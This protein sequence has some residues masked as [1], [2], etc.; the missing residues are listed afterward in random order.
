MQDRPI[1]LNCTRMNIIIPMAGRGTRLRPHT[2]ATP[3]PLLKIGG[4]TIVQR[5]CEEIRG[6]YNSPIDTI[7]F[8]IGDFGAAVEQELLA[9][10]ES[11]G[12]KGKIC[13]QNEPLGTA[14]AIWQAEECL[15]GETIIAFADTLFK[16][17]F[18]LDNTADGVIWVKTVDNPKAFGVV[19]LDA[20]GVINGMVEKPQEFVSDLA[21]IGIYYVKQ[22]ETLHAEIKYLLDNDIREKGEYQLTNALENMRLKGAQFVPGK[23]DSWMDCGNKEA[24]LDTMKHTLAF[25]HSAGKITPPADLKST[26]SVIIPPCYL[27]KGVVLENAVIGPFVSLG[28]NTI[29]KNSVLSMTMAQDHCTIENHVMT[30]S[31]LGGHVRV[32]KPAGILDIG[33]YSKL[34]G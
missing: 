15:K 31:M 23:V 2:I 19:T 25:D 29:V 24:V 3:K 9:N 27:G 10:A 8:V 33:D 20:K 14:H 5:L 32:E 22:G 21:I 26:H 7:A 6:I 16:A 17:D 12:A 1:F 4:K 13:Y 30:H 28:D 11:M 18:I 34:N